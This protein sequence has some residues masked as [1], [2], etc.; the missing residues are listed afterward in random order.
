MESLNLAAV[1]DA[2]L[3]A[4]MAEGDH[5]A[6]AALFRRYQT[7]INRLATQMSRRSRP[8]SIRYREVLVLCALTSLPCEEVSGD[9]ARDFGYARRL[10][11][12]A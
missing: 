12:H 11:R 6:L 1:T 8:R 2:D 10:N 3:L 5:E 9:V 4:R 7:T